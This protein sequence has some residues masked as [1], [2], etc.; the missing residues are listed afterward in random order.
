M[1]RHTLD[2]SILG[3]RTRVTGRISGEGGLRIEGTV[4]GDVTVAGE[5]EIAEGG[6]VE[7]NVVAEALD[8]SGSLLGDASVRGPIAVRA[9]AL[10]RGDLRGSE[11]SIEPGSRVSVRLETEFELDF[12]GPQRRR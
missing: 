12:G 9:G 1:A 6:G 3:P 2:V 11:V 7:G 4:R 8:V 10:V 5:A